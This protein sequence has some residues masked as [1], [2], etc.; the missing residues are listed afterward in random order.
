ML[1]HAPT[2][3]T[4]WADRRQFEDVYKGELDELVRGTLLPHRAISRLDHLGQ[5]GH[6]RARQNSVCEHTRVHSFAGVQACSA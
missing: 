5:S 6:W 2:A 1:L 4:D 3:V